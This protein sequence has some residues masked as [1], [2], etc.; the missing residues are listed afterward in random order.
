MEL[1]KHLKPIYQQ[2]MQSGNCISYLYKW[3]PY[4]IVHL[5]N[6]L[7]P[8]KVNAPLKIIDEKTPHFPFSRGYFCLECHCEL[9]GPLE[10]NQK[11]HYRRNKTTVYHEDAVATLD[12]VEIKDS[13]WQQMRLGIIPRF[14]GFEDKYED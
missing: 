2:E 12:T 7:K 14:V 4:F 5:K 10:K 1:C 3:E 9:E 11:N 13:L 6:K 8:Y